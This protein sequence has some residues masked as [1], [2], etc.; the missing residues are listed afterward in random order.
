MSCYC[1]DF[2]NCL[3]CMPRSKAD[4]WRKD[5]EQRAV[6][7]KKRSEASK[8]ANRKQSA[9]T[10]DLKDLIPEMTV[11]RMQEALR[12]STDRRRLFEE[13]RYAKPKCE[14]STCVVCKG[15]VIEEY[16][17][18]ADRPFTQI[19]LGPGSRNCF[20]WRY[21]GCHCTKCG[22]KYEFLPPK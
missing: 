13:E 11:E 22:L 17:Q 8:K 1:G 2:K 20:S 16:T 3:Q 15:T 5:N 6:V 12:R 10:G 21:D 9:I 18:V 19:P 14:E 7:K 4:E